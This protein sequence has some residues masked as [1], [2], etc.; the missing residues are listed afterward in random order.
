MR[1]LVKSSDVSLC[2]ILIS[3]VLFNA[4][5]YCYVTPHL[6]IQNEHKQPDYTDLHSR[7]TIPYQGFL[8]STI[9]P[10]ES[11]TQIGTPLHTKQLSTVQYLVVDLIK[12]SSYGYLS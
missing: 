6:H 4:V 5:L 3:L 7:S 9:E 1:C 10:H 11:F 12:A 8:S 2:G